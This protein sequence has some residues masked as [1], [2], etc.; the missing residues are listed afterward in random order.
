MIEVILYNSSDD[1]AVLRKN[2]T[3]AISCQCSFYGEFSKES[4]SI[5]LDQTAAKQSRNYCFIPSYGRYYFIN[6][7]SIQNNHK[8][9]LELQEDYLMSFKDQILNSQI[10]ADRSASAWEPYIPD[11]VVHDSGKIRIYQRKLNKVF[12]NSSGN[13][14]VLMVGG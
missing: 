9:I 4:P 13:N 12:S 3:D 11:D 5:I 10:I 1:P 7:T 14:Y 2:L 6:S 8:L